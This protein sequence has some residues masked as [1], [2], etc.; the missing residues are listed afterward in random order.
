MADNRWQFGATGTGVRQTNEHAVETAPHPW[1]LNVRRL[2]RLAMLLSPILWLSLILSVLSLFWL[3]TWFDRIIESN[4]II[5]SSISPLPG[6]NPYAGR[7]AEALAGL[8]GLLQVNP[9]VSDRL[10]VSQLEQAVSGIA[11]LSQPYRSFRRPTVNLVYVNCPGL[12]LSHQ[13]KL[14]P[15]LLPTNVYGSSSTVYER[16]VP[17]Q[18]VLENLAASNSSYKVLVLDCQQLASFWPAGVIS[19]Q[20]VSSVSKLL[21]DKRGEYPNL[22]VL[23]SCSD[24]EVSWN[25]DSIGHSVF[26]R[27][28]LQGITGAADK[29][30][31]NDRKVS[32]DELHEYVRIN[33]NLWTQKNRGVSQQPF[34]LY[35]GDGNA[36]NF[37]RDV[38]LTIVT[39]G[40][41]IWQAKAMTDATTQKERL[42]ELQTSW[43]TYYQT[44]RSLPSPTS[45]APQLF[46]LWEDSLL[47]AEASLRQHNEQ[48][49]RQAVNMANDY[50]RQVR[51]AQERYSFG[52]SAF[53]LPMIRM[54]TNPDQ[55]VSGTSP[56]GN[57]ETKGPSD[58]L[59]SPKKNNVVPNKASDTRTSAGE[60]PAA[61]A[62]IGTGP[63]QQNAH[64][65]NAN[66]VD[67]AN[68][69]G[70]GKSPS[71]TTHQQDKPASVTAESIPAKPMT[72]PEIRSAMTEIEAN[73]GA[74]VK[75]GKQLQEREHDTLPAEAELVRMMVDRWPTDKG[76]GPL[77][78]FGHRVINSR[79]QVEQ[80]AVPGGHFAYRIFPWVKAPMKEVDQLQR[81]IEDLFF[82]VAG[83]PSTV[84]RESWN[85][86]NNKMPSVDEIKS[87]GKN[88]ATAYALRDQSISALPGL[89]KFYRSS[90]ISYD[91]QRDQIIEG[92]HE[93]VNE[94]Y[95]LC[96]DLRF[97]DDLAASNQADK[98]QDLIA[99]SDR[100]APIYFQLLK[101]INQEY[102]HLS[103]SI[104][105]KL[106]L[107]ANQWK[108]LDAILKIPFDYSQR[109]RS[110]SSSSGSVSLFDFLE[111]PNALATRRVRL[112][113]R[114][115]LFAPERRPR[116]PQS[117]S[118]EATAT[119]KTVG[120]HPDEVATAEFATALFSLPELV[121]TPL[122]PA[123]IQNG[124][125]ST[126]AGA[127]EDS[128]RAATL[129]LSQ[130][131]S[132][133]IIGDLASRII[134]PQ[135]LE[136]KWVFLER[137][138]P[139]ML[140]AQQLSAFAQWH[141][142]RRAGDLWSTPTE[143]GT[144]Y[145][146]KTSGNLDRLAKKFV[147]SQ[148]NPQKVSSSS[149]DH[150]GF[151]QVTEEPYSIGLQPD[152]PA[153]TFRGTDQ[154]KIRFKVQLPEDNTA[155]HVDLRLTS[156]SDQLTIS[157]ISTDRGELEYQI[158]RKTTTEFN[159]VVTATLFFRGSSIDRTIPV[160]SI[161]D[162]QGPTV[163]YDYQVLNE[164][165]LRVSLGDVSRAPEHLLFVLDSSRSMAEL[166]RLQEV[167]QVLRTFS[168]SVSQNGISVG[169]RVF[170][171]RIVWKENDVYS[172]A[173]ARKDTQLVL[174]LRAFP[175]T[176]FRETISRLKPVGE[177]PLFYSLL[178]AKNDFQYVNPGSR[179][180]I[181]ISD[182]SDNWADQGL[183]PG[184]AQLQTAYQDSGIPI[185]AI[186]FKSDLQGWSQLQ[187][188]ADVTGGKAVKIDHA[189]D[190]LS[191]V[192]DLAQMR[193]FDV[194]PAPTG[195]SDLPRQLNFSGADLP[196]KP[197][198]YNVRILD[199]K[200]NPMAKTSVPI[201]PGQ[202]HD[203]VFRGGEL[204]YNPF[205]ERA[206]KA[207]FTDDKTGVSLIIS[208]FTFD[209]GVLNVTLALSHQ[210]E[211]NWWP[212]SVQFKLQPHNHS[213]IYSVANVS[214]NVAGH[215]IP[216]W[217]ITLNEWPSA[218]SFARVSASWQ[219]TDRR[220]KTYR[221]PLS[222]RS[223]ITNPQLP[224]GIRVTR[225]KQ[226]LRQIEGVRKILQHITLVSDSKPSILEWS[227]QSGASF[228]YSRQ[229][230]N[231]AEGIYNV[232]FL[233]N[234]DTLEAITLVQQ[235][236]ERSRIQGDIDLRAP[237]LD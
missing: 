87:A 198:T 93:L 47:N 205:D 181:A 196:V 50:A 106:Y 111:S 60:S 163:D 188:I 1:R 151:L 70:T 215:H 28:F 153:I 124:F 119:P 67:G 182:G 225:D 76:Q 154:E 54:F 63:T 229:N 156:D 138:P 158:E 4:T 3:A 201:R 235:T 211:P 9:F 186:G 33:V 147:S 180:I 75:Y 72:L 139:Q 40:H 58:R 175:G 203:L 80:A 34:M 134:D 95:Q 212:K 96:G 176:A 99:Q 45:C 127:W 162:W 24:N 44:A 185:D 137:T 140:R 77:R 132:N 62:E 39:A 166:Q 237:K 17:V 83:P 97:V 41:P 210:H 206:S 177:S 16:V 200:D 46:R 228:G 64:A 157:Q 18:K 51:A 130:I 192:L 150:P 20:F 223:L 102:L 168:D 94:N 173:E 101:L 52:N 236:G 71:D 143:D 152:R 227:L 118:E 26:S 27:Y 38:P 85:S 179:R 112:L 31:T 183:A 25:D 191:C 90:F 178:E 117:S 108:R 30:G 161:G 226:S 81:E 155:N 128:Y 224:D 217:T 189:N 105:T 171:S 170:G 144:P 78:D 113:E 232:E 218:A 66:Q 234:K 172:E 221:L 2:N 32:L 49:M 129:N 216:V 146:L 148:Q 230:Y 187:N 7:D 222:N 103:E 104:G 116:P 56:I 12:A 123:S 55:S 82:A 209:D 110:Q 195:I 190:L 61:D 48:T 107:S 74:V 43:Q 15:Y 86:L 207:V 68:N 125:S 136:S 37:A 91:E 213:E 53:S 220:L 214:P 88:L 19:N 122:S 208:D 100:V 21:D 121:S 165:K 109:R 164:A 42:A 141:G 14:V 11:E 219:N 167:K 8:Q 65:K 114:I 89:A 193:R 98:L 131:R 202:Q 6:V 5:L 10:D 59:A 169:I 199:P 120:L 22:F 57:Q 84:D 135:V 133:L 184:I 159:T 23:M 231:V 92:T 197:G 142:Q 29:S 145:Y 149:S 126:L 174:P 204:T 36:Q 160:E 233:P 73:T 194:Q 69:D 13:D 35:T 115:S 79:I